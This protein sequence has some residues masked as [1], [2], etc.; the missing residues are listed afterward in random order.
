MSELR[1]YKIHP[2]R[3]MGA[4]QPT[5]VYLA[6]PMRG[7]P[8]FNFPAFDEATS[9]L[10]EQ[11]FEVWSP[12]ERDREEGFDPDRDEAK[13]LAYYMAFDLKAVCESDAIVV[14]PG[15]QRSKGAT[16][17]LHV[18]RECEIPIYTYPD[19][20][21]LRYEPERYEDAEG[22]PEA[23]TPVTEALA[24]AQPSPSARTS[25]DIRRAAESEREW[26][27][28]VQEIKPWEPVTRELLEEADIVRQFDT[29]ATRNND[30]EQPD[31][32]G[33]LSP[34]AV[35]EFGSYMHRHREQPDGTIRDS[36]NWQKGIPSDSYAK[37]LWR[38]NLDAWLAH[39]GYPEL[40]REDLKSALCAILFN[41][42]GWLHEIVKAELEE[43]A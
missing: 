10:R 17:E 4:V 24:A 30:A 32:E 18:A 38:H 9:T 33:F 39:R 3:T 41:A 25:E 37:S 20:Q 36:D 11:G 26:C 27:D 28:G 14:L 13:T 2:G 22:E 29:G 5:R 31:Y 12:A 42:G 19:L 40:A 23:E 15:W 6:G 21:P 35:R 1:P 8:S 7:L 16:L 34:L 43:A